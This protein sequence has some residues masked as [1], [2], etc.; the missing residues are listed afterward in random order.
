[1]AVLHNRSSGGI[2]CSW[3]IESDLRVL[4]IYIRT[5]LL[6]VPLRSTVAFGYSISYNLGDYRH[7]HSQGWRPLTRGEEPF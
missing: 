6:S 1:M 3:F 7:P 5:R 4:F 2:I